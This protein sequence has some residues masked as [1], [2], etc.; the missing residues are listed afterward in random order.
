MFA[1]KNILVGVTGGISAYKTCDLVRDLVKASAQVRVMMTESAARFVSALTFE[2]LSGHPVLLDLFPP[3]GG[4]AVHIEWA[5]WPQAICLCPASANTVAKLAAGIADNALLATLLATTAPV[6]FCPAMNKA[7]YTHPAYQENQQK[8]IDRGYRLVT[9]GQGALACGEVGWGRLADKADIIDAIKI[10]L[11]AGPL[12]Q[13]RRVLI[14]AGPTREPLDPVRFLSNRSSGKMGYALA[15]AAALQGAQVTLV[16]GPTQLR[17]FSAVNLIRVTTAQE[18]AEA[19]LARLADHDVLIAAAAVSDFRPE[20][21]QAQKIKKADHALT[22]P[23]VVNPD[24]LAAAAE[25]KGSRIH[26]GFSLETDQEIERSRKKLQAKKLDL[27]VINNP[28][29][30]GAGFDV[31][32][33][34]VTLLDAQ[35]EVESWPLLS[36]RQVAAQIIE[37]IAQLGKS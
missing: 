2:T 25:V 17:P 31:D 16:S 3:T 14:T 34:L 27:V 5:R 21:V 36:K 10:T 26:V 9:P 1:G 7:M 8:L 6:L 20:R 4:T 32:T 22:L 15:E 24:I 29:Q 19:T 37:K 13:G 30:P 18:M 12:L 28:Q 11:L 23:L 35:G 33:N